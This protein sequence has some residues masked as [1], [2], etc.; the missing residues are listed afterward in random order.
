MQAVADARLTH[1]S[2]VGVL[3]AAGF[4][5][6]DHEEIFTSAAAGQGPDGFDWN[7]FREQYLHTVRPRAMARWSPGSIPALI[8]RQ[9]AFTGPVMSVMTACAA[10]T[11]ALGDAARWI[12]YGDADVVVAGGSDSE[13]S[14]MGLASFCL[15]R[16]LSRRNDEPQRASRPFSAT[17]DGFVLGEG[18]GVLVL[19]E[20][21]HALARSAHIYAELLGF[22]SSS[23]SYRVT[24]PHPDGVGAT[25]Q[26]GMWNADVDT[27]EIVGALGRIV[28]PHAFICGPD[29]GDFTL[30]VGDE[31]RTVV[32]PAVDH[33][34][35]QVDR[36]DRAVRGTGAL[37]FGP[38][39]AVAGAGVLEAASRSWRQR[40]RV[41]ISA[42]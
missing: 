6:Y 28:V 3:L 8:A 25:A 12:R 16:A 10:G 38:D 30:V 1:G 29:Q 14:P 19:E 37:L 34:V 32:V 22:G 33:Y 40:E 5:S 15:L 7:A 9:Y 24:D 17:R 41:P 31:S 39:D 11:Q 36:F 13:I 35:C 42:P 23:D 21:E 26:I 27:I 4:S 20:C 18:A 2:H